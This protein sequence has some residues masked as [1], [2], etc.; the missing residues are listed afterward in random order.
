MDKL[1][2]KIEFLIESALTEIQE[3]DKDP[4]LTPKERI[5]VA[6]R[7]KDSENRKLTDNEIASA[8][9]NKENNIPEMGD[10]PDLDGITPN[11]HIP[12]GLLKMAAQH[13]EDNS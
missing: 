13:I 8:V 10:N 11:P 2:T 5:N 1:L 6:E 9:K 7:A 12:G 4:G 3:S